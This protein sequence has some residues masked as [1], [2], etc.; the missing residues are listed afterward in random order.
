MNYLKEKSLL[1]TSWPMAM[2]QEKDLELLAELEELRQENH[3]LHSQMDNVRD[4]LLSEDRLGEQY[5]RLKTL[6]GQEKKAGDGKDFLRRRSGELCRALE[7]QLQALPAQVIF[8]EPISWSSSVWINVG[9][10]DNQALGRTIVAKNSPVL[11]G[12][13][14]V[15]VVE[16]V[17]N[18]RARVRLITDAHLSPSVRAVRGREQ[19]RFV[20]EHLDALQ[21]ALQMRGDLFNSQQAAVHLFAQ[22]AEMR[23][24]LG[25]QDGEQYL[26][27]GE[28]CGTSFPLWRSRSQVLKGAGFNYDIADREG[29]ARDLRTGEVFQRTWK[30]QAAP[31]LRAGDLL[32]TTGLDGVFP[33]GFRVAVVSHVSM[34]KE[35][36]SS[37]EIEAVP[38][39]GDLNTLSRVTVLPP[40]AD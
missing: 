20:T 25:E 35:G 28:I 12:T 22:L 36:S 32:V 21:F 15:G 8:R 40:L 33:A 37:Y 26:A 38:T 11:M 7:R 16:Y 30:G 1:L 24:K 4:W 29:P 2:P 14:I 18:S 17:G 13:S 23:K 19:N 39:A 6:V 27:K 9:E 5:E 34:L 10:R 31:L 3:L